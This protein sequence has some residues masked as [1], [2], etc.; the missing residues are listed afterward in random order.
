[1][2]APFLEI[3]TGCGV[4]SSTGPLYL[5]KRNNGDNHLTGYRGT[6]L[7]GVTGAKPSSGAPPRPCNSASHYGEKAATQLSSAGFAHE[8][9]CCN[10]SWH[11]R[12]VGNTTP[13]CDSRFPLSILRA[14]WTL[15]FHNTDAS[16]QP[17]S[18][19]CITKPGPHAPDLETLLFKDASLPPFGQRKGDGGLLLV[20]SPVRLGHPAGGAAQL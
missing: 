20:R 14:P 13:V 18:L 19:P 11:Q 8:P 6:W 16:R 7:Q 15:F 9:P 4:L 3:G 2:E 5:R 17:E 10:L 1:M 12:C